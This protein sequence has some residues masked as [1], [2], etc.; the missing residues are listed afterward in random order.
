MQAVPP[1]PA[2][3]AMHAPGLAPIYERVWRPLALRSFF[4]GPSTAHEERLTLKLLELRPGD[5]V[6]DVCCGPGNTTRRLL[7][8]LGADGLAVGLDAAP[9]MLGQAVRDT[10]DQRVTYVRADAEQL[11][12]RD[13]SF[14]AIT[15][16]AAL[17]MIERPVTAIN[18]MARVLAPG[19]R[20]VLLTSCQRGPLPLRLAATMATWPSGIRMFARDEITSM[21]AQQRFTDISQDVYGFVQ[22][23]GARK[24]TESAVA[25]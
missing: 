25:S 3:Q 16:H 18:E 14:N 8:A 21:L 5:A 12:F 22:L 1:T 15:C 10:N 9:S 2:Q 23:V 24:P 13:C 11:P 17:Y 4:A 19:G 20:I 7:P 6:L